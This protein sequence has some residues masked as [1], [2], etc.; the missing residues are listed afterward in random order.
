MTLRAFATLALITQ[1][2]VAVSVAAGPAVGAQANQ[3]VTRAENNRTFI[4]GSEMIRA[5]A[6]SGADAQIFIGGLTMF[7]G[8]LPDL[9]SAAVAVSAYRPTVGTAGVATVRF[10][11]ADGCDVGVDTELQAG[12]L[13]LIINTI[14]TRI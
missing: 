8:S 5:T 14:G 12:M 6:Y 10:Y 7:V 4:V 13:D 11:G 2:L 1:S 9:I 3:C